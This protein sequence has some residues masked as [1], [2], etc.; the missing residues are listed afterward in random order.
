MFANYLINN[1][2][3][4]IMIKILLIDY[5]AENLIKHNVIN[6]IIVFG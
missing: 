4:F 3:M 5:F 2:I 1:V 6:K